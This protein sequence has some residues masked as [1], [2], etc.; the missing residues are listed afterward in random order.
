MQRGPEGG[1]SRPVTGTM[2][3]SSVPTCE[4]PGLSAAKEEA[5]DSTARATRSVPNAVRMAR[6]SRPVAAM[7]AE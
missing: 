6:Y 2:T 5:Q 4:L 7:T 3:A 1:A